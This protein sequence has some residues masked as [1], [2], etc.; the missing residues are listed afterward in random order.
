MSQPVILSAKRTPI[1]RFLGGLSRESEVR[2]KRET[3]VVRKIPILGALFRERE[4]RRDLTERLFLITP[5]LVSPKRIAKQ[6]SEA[7]A[8]PAKAFDEDEESK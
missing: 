6:S 7:I 5:R 4:K 8:K 2:R 3:P 1:G